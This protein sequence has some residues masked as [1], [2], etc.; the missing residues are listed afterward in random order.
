M[1]HTVQRGQSTRVDFR[2]QLV[3]RFVKLG[4]PSIT[5]DEPGVTVEQN[6]T[7]AAAKA[8]V[9]NGDAR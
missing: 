4:S 6:Q 5:V 9:A 7:I 2:L 1:P 8:D 3:N